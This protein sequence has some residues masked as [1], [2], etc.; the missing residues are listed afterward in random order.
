MV[1]KH[2]NEIDIAKILSLPAWIRARAARFL[3]KWRILK[4]KSGPDKTR[5]SADKKADGYVKRP[6]HYFQLGLDAAGKEFEINELVSWATLGSAFIKATD[7]VLHAKNIEIRS[8]GGVDRQLDLI[9]DINLAAKAFLTF[10]FGE[11]RSAV[12]LTYGQLFNIH[13]TFPSI[14]SM[15][16]NRARDKKV[17]ELRNK[18]VVLES[19]KQAMEHFNEEEKLEI[20]RITDFTIVK[21]IM[22]VSHCKYLYASFLVFN[23]IMK[24][25]NILFRN[26][27]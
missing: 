14:L 15:W 13:Q 3:A 4:S 16:T 23:F 8:Q 6:L 22:K 1:E 12:L 19:D 17:L 20:L 21:E 27:L 25:A 24:I 18:G 10:H 9:A 26:V 11:D 2:E 5:S 7:V